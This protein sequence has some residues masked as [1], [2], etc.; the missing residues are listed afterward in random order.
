MRF[1]LFY[2]FLLS[3]F[4]MTFVHGE[5]SISLL[6]FRT[7]TVENGLPN[8]TVNHIAN[9]SLGF[10]WI[11]SPGG[12]TRFDGHSFKNFKAPFRFDHTNTQSFIIA[13]GKIVFANGTEVYGFN[14]DNY[15]WDHLFDAPLSGK[16]RKLTHTPDR[17][18]VY[19]IENQLGIFD[20]S[21]QQL[22]FKEFN[23]PIIDYLL[24][25]DNTSV[26]L[27]KDSLVQVN[28][29]T[30]NITKSIPCKQIN[31][32]IDAHSNV[33]YGINQ[34]KIFTLNSEGTWEL[35]CD[36]KQHITSIVQSENSLWIGTDKAGIIRLDVQTKEEQ[37]LNSTNSQLGDDHIISLHLD[38]NNHL[39]VGSRYG[40]IQQLSIKRSSFL[41]LH[42]GNIPGLNSDNIVGMAELPNQ[43]ILL[44]TQKESYIWDRQAGT[45]TS[46]MELQPGSIFTSVY[47]HNDQC[48]VG[49]N[50]GIYQLNDQKLS[51]VKGTRILNIHS[52]ARRK[53]GIWIIVTNDSEFIQADSLF[54]VRS[55]IV[56]GKMRSEESRPGHI[57]SLLITQQDQV[58][59]A[60]ENGLFQFQ[61]NL[62]NF[63][64]TK[65]L[66]RNQQE[67]S[68]QINTLF[69]DRSGNLWA[70]LK[71]GGLSFFSPK[72]N[73]L[74]NFGIE[75][76]FSGQSV[77]SIEQDNNG[78]LWL[79]TTQGL[80]R[81]TPGENRFTLFTTA[82]GIQDN[83][84]NINSSVKLANGELVFGGIN[85]I[86]LFNPS[87]FQI[88]TF[89]SPIAVTA[90]LIDN[91]EYVDLNE[92]ITLNHDQNDIY[93]E[94]SLLNHTQSGKNTYAIWMENLQDDWLQL[95]N[96]HAFSFNNIAPGNYTLHITGWNN[97]GVEG[98]TKTISIS[99][100]PPWWKT[101]WAYFIYLLI[102][103]VIIAVIFR[104]VAQRIRLRNQLQIEKIK[105]QQSE[106]LINF[107]LR[108]YTNVS[109]EIRTPLTLITGP[110]NKLTGLIA[111]NSEAGRQVDIMN[112]NTERLLKLVEQLL[113]FRKL[114]SDKLPFRPVNM[115]I[116]SFVK[117]VLM[118]FEG[119]AE[120]K[121]IH[122][123]S[124]IP[125]ERLIAGF[126]PDKLEKIIFNL[127]SNAVKH[128]PDDNGEV[129]VELINIDNIIQLKVTDNGPGI[130][131]DRREK[132]FQRFESEGG[133][134]IGLALTR[135]LVSMHEGSIQFKPVST[136]GSCFI[137]EIPI[138]KYTDAVEPVKETEIQSELI[139]PANSKTILIVEDNEELRTYIAGIFSDNFKTIVAGNGREGLELI[140][141]YNPQLIISDV[142]MPVMD[143][144][145]LCKA[146]KSNIET[147]HIPIILLTAY[148]DIKHRLEGAESGADLYVAKPFNS[149]LLL[150][151]VKSIL[152][153]R[154]RMQERF[155]SATSVEPEKISTNKLDQKLID[156]V[157]K[158]ITNHLDNPEL[159]VE[160]LAAEINLSRS[161]L[162]RK[163]KELSGVSPGQFIQNYRL[164]NAGKLLKTTELNITEVA[165]KCGFSD[166]KYFSRNFKKLFGVSPSDYR[167]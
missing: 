19:S 59:L 117:E 57:N 132:I 3:F 124:H 125:S 10:I 151:N 136:G 21:T 50:R 74:V 56:P 44:V 22:K 98:Q 128:A 109:H 95:A 79:G 167:G 36:I 139:I 13:N 158:I 133:F 47:Q 90:F 94:F 73:S 119:L 27:F 135:E 86:N 53:N 37:V 85:G 68:N 16:I 104:F 102:S 46:N 141:L 123:I 67:V 43:K 5:E 166:P 148:A 38:N 118:A 75:D 147:S 20:E 101:S 62:M 150:S 61:E 88:N 60:T 23:E 99:I 71:N 131:K 130:D 92:T 14:L 41:H 34:D 12:L 29:K 78:L 143:G 138:K 156:Q 72:E 165:Y 149:E 63:K 112:R 108:F 30:L 45:A 42:P 8:N 82:D 114:E 105:R 9:D 69:E 91:K 113:D 137:V 161:Q 164:R 77:V 127:L 2:I 142:M 103:V 70:G 51:Y 15:Q 122:L 162:T 110:L 28:L 134:G 11:S 18:L 64:I 93:V 145:E 4:T 153:N 129:S 81:F 84:F 83:Q 32:L 6:K 31:Q 80:S 116:N 58:F 76:G 7:L 152:T 97:D 140:S 35:F 25:A 155:S 163:M 26:L 159:G 49:S 1:K 106:E 126:D 121:S 33:I 48:Y 17:R 65:H 115:E 144:F 154:Q 107:K 100:N 40:G 111:K 55:R 54:N 24:R 39:W 157:M 160:L 120:A 87:K 52:F 146:V 89:K 96:R 66:N